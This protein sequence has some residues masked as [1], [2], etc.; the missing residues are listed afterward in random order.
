MSK[1]V[2][3]YGL[4]TCTYPHKLVYSEEEWTKKTLE[5]RYRT[6]LMN[7]LKMKRKWYVVIGIHGWANYHHR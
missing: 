3:K 2:K 6:S 4:E 5:A 7:S 1:A